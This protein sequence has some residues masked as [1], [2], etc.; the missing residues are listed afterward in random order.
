MLFEMPYFVVHVEEEHKVLISSRVIKDSFLSLNNQTPTFSDLF[1][2][3]TQPEFWFCK[4]H[5]FVGKGDS[6]WNFIQEGLQD[7]LSLLITL[8]FTH[9]KF[10]ILIHIY[11]NLICKNYIFWVFSWNLINLK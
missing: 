2:N 7:E 11:K 9:I 3:L 5:V 1:E 10:G 8:G 6:K 4:V